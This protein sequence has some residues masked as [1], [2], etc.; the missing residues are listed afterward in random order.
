MAIETGKISYGGDMMLFVG[1]GTDKLPIAFSTDA[2]LDITL[3]T[4]NIASK[5]SGYWTNKA[6]G[7]LDWNASTSALHSDVL[8]A[9]TGTNTYDELYTLMIARTPVNCVFAA[10]TGTAPDWTVNSAKKNFTGMAI[11]TSLSLG[12]PDG[13]NATYSISLEGDGALVMA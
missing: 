5:D 8:T 4:R 11:I 13:D 2:K 12:A 3:A 6:G 9:T 1:S 7:R 10:A